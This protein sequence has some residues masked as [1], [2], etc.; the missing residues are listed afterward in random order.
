LE[1]VLQLDA[2]LN[3]NQNQVP[4]SISEIGVFW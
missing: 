4:S 3:K 2:E 1:P